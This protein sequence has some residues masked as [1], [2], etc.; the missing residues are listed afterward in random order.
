CIG[1]LPAGLTRGHTLSSSAPDRWLC[2]RGY[3]VGQTR[4][5]GRWWV[6]DRPSRRNTPTA[7]VAVVYTYWLM[8]GVECF[9]VRAPGYVSWLRALTA[10]LRCLVRGL[11]IFLRVPH[12]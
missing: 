8:D 10:V 7:R 1:G 2:C 12:S 3:G 5:I 6:R 11:A 4:G 9:A